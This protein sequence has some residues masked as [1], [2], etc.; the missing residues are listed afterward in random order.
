MRAPGMTFT[1]MPLFVWGQFVTAPLLM[2]ATT[3]LGAALAALFIQREFG[4]PFFDPTKGGSPLLWQHMFWFYSHPAVYIMILP[5]FGGDLGDLSDVRA[6]TDL[7]LQDD[8]LLV[9]RDR[10]LG[11]HGL[12]TSHVHLGHGTGAAAAVHGAH[13][14]DRDPHG[15]QDL[16]V[17]DDALRRRAAFHDGDDVRGRFL[18]D[19]H[20][21]RY[22]GRL[23]GR[24][25]VRSCT[26]TARTS[27]SRICTTSWWAEV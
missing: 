19:V 15:H 9:M 4:V 23:L 5:A 3:A 2:I 13:D 25:S 14:A 11:L 6:K 17:D 8:R 21:G 7:R 18:G 12:G 22:H 24:G 26:R 20:A 10:D 16:L 1:R 27:S